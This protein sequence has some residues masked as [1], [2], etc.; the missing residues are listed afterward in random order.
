MVVGLLEAFGLAEEVGRMVLDS[1]DFKY[2]ILC[3]GKMGCARIAN[4]MT[5]ADRR[6]VMELGIRC[7]EW[8]EQNR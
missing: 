6:R 5:A 7:K 1:D 3:K 2:M 8:K 4:T